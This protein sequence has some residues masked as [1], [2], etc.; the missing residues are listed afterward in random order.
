VECPKC[1]NII[2]DNETICPKCHKV[3]ALECPNCHSI[4][5][6]AICQKC[7]YTILVKCSK[8]SKT[9][10]IKNEI[11]SKCKFPVK[12]SLAY[13][14]CESDSFASITV[15]FGALKK[16]RTSL[17]SQELYTKFLIKLKNL[18]LA[19]IKGVECKLITYGDIYVINMNKELSFPTSAN[20]AT[21]LALKIV[22]A[23][24]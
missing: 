4:G 16:I 19:Q 7:G 12:T 14:E 23:F 6:S 1:H 2:K 11:C 17:K 3:L 18:L 5:D 10:H 13:Q 9:N 21:R 8:C 20:K 22:N 24:T 15:S